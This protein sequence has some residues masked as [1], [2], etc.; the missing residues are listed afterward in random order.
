M[1]QDGCA[2]SILTW[3]LGVALTVGVG[4][5]AV[6]LLVRFVKWAWN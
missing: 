1:N 4:G 6:Y 2:A 3:L 5:G